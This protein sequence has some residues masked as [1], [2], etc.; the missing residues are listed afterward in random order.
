[1]NYGSLEGMLQGL[2]VTRSLLYISYINCI[3][4][5]T[6]ARVYTA[7]RLVTRRY[8][9][10]THTVYTVYVDIYFLFNYNQINDFWMLACVTQT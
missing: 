4:R 7:W 9:I 2:K 8:I 3:I 10:S 1:M 5:I 6:Q